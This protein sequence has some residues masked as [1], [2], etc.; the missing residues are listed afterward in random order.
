MNPMWLLIFLF[1]AGQSAVVLLLVLP[2]P[3]NDMRGLLVKFLSGVW[4]QSSWLRNTCTTLC[5]IN[6]IMFLHDMRALYLAPPLMGSVGDFEPGMPRMPPPP[7]NAMHCEAKL[8]RFR[9][10][11]NTYITGFSLLIFFVMRRLLVIQTQLFKS[12]EAAK[13]AEKDAVTQKKNK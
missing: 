2:M 1:L 5:V 12:R 8:V 9:T 13:D 10:E 3:R 11:R 4:N 6:A 7:P